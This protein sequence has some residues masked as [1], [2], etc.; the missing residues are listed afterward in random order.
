MDKL[1]KLNPKHF[2]KAVSPLR[3]PKFW[4]I[5]LVP[6]IVILAI[7]LPIILTWEKKP[8]YNAFLANPDGSYTFRGN[9]D[10]KDRTEITVPA[11]HNGKAVTIISYNA[12][13]DFKKV[14]KIT[15]PETITEI[16]DGAFQGCTALTDINLPNSIT[17][18]QQ[19]AFRNC[20]TLELIIWPPNLTYID[21]YMFS[22]CKKLKNLYLTSTSMVQTSPTSFDNIKETITRIWISSNSLFQD[23]WN[24]E[25]EYWVWANGDNRDLFFVGMPPSQT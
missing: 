8:P 3:T 2:K 21:A 25:N 15:L 9:P 13:K 7:A 24:P 12:F 6:V 4:A 17:T 5:I 11:T 22:D 16:H 1:T 20:T 19:S 10:W 14:T 23:Y 18:I